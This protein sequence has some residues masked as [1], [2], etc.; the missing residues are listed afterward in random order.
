M[1]HVMTHDMELYDVCFVS[2][3]T[4]G[5]GEMVQKNELGLQSKAMLL[6][7][8]SFPAG[9]DCC[10]SCSVSPTSDLANPGDCTR[11]SYRCCRQDPPPSQARPLSGRIHWGL[12]LPLPVFHVTTGVCHDTDTAAVMSC[13]IEE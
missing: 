7:F 13:L 3:D 11:L 5:E 4:R 9:K 2:S 6:G 1:I 8:P 12:Q 10:L